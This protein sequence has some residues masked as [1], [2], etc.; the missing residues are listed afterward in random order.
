[1]E[2]TRKGVVAMNKHKTILVTE[3]D[4]ERIQSLIESCRSSW[5]QD[6]HDLDTLEGELDKAKI[7][8]P[9]D[10]PPNV[11]T[12]NSR[13]RVKNIT[14]GREFVCQIVF[15]K[16]A[17]SELNRISILAPIGTALL[18]Y[19]TGSTVEWQMPSGTRRLKVLS[20]EYQ[21]EA[22]GSAADNRRLNPR[23]TQSLVR[24]VA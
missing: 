15:P 11:V 10:I 7:V 23:S 18:G 21:P 19:R 22:A 1:M 9:A 14:S 8:K 13:V 12:M 5:R 24:G 2:T 16:D 17:D 3:S 4:F 20:V 6:L